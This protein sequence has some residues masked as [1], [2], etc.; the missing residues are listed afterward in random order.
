MTPAHVAISR[1]RR[2]LTLGSAVKFLLVGSA[3]ASLLLD[4]VIDLPVSGSMILVIAGAIWLILSYRSAQNSRAAAASPSLIAAGRFDEAEERI[5]QSLRT[6]SLFRAVKL[7]SLHHLAMLRHAQRRW[8]DSALLTRTLLQ[9][10]LGGAQALAKPSRLMLAD[11]LLE[12]DDLRGVHETIATL[13][14]GRLTLAE[15][16]QLLLIQLDY[17]ARIGAWGEMLQGI[18]AKIQLM[19]LMPSPHSARAQAFLALAA[20]KSGKIELSD[21]LRRRVEL[22]TD[23]Q[24]LTAERKMLRELWEQ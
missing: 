7:L 13:Y 1:F 2:N 9:Q 23:A 14:N 24:S 12:M 18:A 21:W 8:Q 4:N 22:L 5:D 3:A 16:I 15:A 20:K 10:R 17:C 19:E 6:F 11:A